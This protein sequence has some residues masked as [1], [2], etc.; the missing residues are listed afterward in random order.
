MEYQSFRKIHYDTANELWE[1]LSPTKSFFD[2][3]YSLIYRG[4]ADSSWLL[5]P[6]LLRNEGT[7]SLLKLC[8]RRS[9]TDELV[10]T[11]VRLLEV[12]AEY[13]DNIGIKIPNDSIKFRR[14]TLNP[15]SQDKYY[16]RPELWPNPDLI[17]VMALA[18][19]HGVPT[20]LLDWTR[21]PYVAVYFAVSSAMNNLKKRVWG[22]DTNLAIWALNTESV[23]LYKNLTLVQ[24]PGSTSNYLSAQSGLF[25]VHPHIGARNGDFEI[26]GLEHAFTMMPDT[27]LLKLTLPVS[28]VISLYHLCS[29]AGINGATIYPSAD[30]AGKAVQ[31]DI[32]SWA[33]NG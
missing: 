5:V 26:K 18:Q 19:H 11:E 8:G 12:F 3:P 23:N 29:K 24:V 32:N 27:P 16:I 13:C 33:I 22:E 21:Q 30:G 2:E 25:T 10:F 28:E 6:S 9:K 31:D 17:E 7:N 14:E 20:R 4:Q 15:Q 1:A